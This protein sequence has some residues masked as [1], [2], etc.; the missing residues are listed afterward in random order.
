MGEKGTVEA[1][2]EGWRCVLEMPCVNLKDNGRY[3]CVAKNTKGEVFHSAALKVKE[4]IHPPEF[5]E[6]QGDVTVL[7][8]QPLEVNIKCT[9]SQPL[10]TKWIKNG[11]S[12]FN[13]ASVRSEKTEDGVCLKVR[14]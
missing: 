9:G 13:S 8:G 5:S 14:K 11:K 6:I 12:I 1:D 4:L 2:G 7:E 3:K 10:K